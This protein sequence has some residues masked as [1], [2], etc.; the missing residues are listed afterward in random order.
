VIEQEIFDEAL[1][2]IAGAEHFIVADLFLFND[3]L[4]KTG[5]AYRPLAYFLFCTQGTQV[6][7]SG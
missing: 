4:G 2:L 7:A 5:A 3:Y 1:Q 6:T